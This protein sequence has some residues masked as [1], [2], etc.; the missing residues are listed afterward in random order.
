MNKHVLSI[1]AVC[2]LASPG[3]CGAEEG[4][5]RP[6]WMIDIALYPY[7]HT[8]ESDVDFT[9]TINGKLPGRFSYFSYTNFKGVVSDGSAV[10]DTSKQFINFEVSNKLPF[11]LTAQGVLLH[12]DR[13]NFY[14]AGLR[15]RISDTP[16][17]ASFFGKINLI[18]HAS[19]FPVRWGT[20][21]AAADAWAVE[22]FFRLTAPKLSN[23]FY[24]SGF[25]DQT[26][27]EE[28]PG[29]MPSRPVIAEVQVGYRVWKQLH[30]V[31]EYRVNERRPGEHRNIAAGL[32]Y[33]FHFR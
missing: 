6:N 24:L 14:Q 7:Q 8:V 25:Y 15:W 2:V 4:F 11:D 16:G 18:W 27:N 10:F 5:A 9:A 32:E 22:Y 31:S 12:G 30:M 29:F 26:F 20:N 19:V 21:S 3:V 13:D 28:V 33:K 17:L 1:V 23:R